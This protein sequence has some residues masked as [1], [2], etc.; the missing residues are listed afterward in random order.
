MATA[1][2]YL[3]KMDFE[4]YFS[5]AYCGRCGLKSCEDFL[6]KA[7]AGLIKPEVCVCLSKQEKYAFE[8]VR[9]MPELWPDVPLLV[10]P[11]RSFVGLMELNE[12]NEKSLILLTGNNEFTQQILMTVL[13]TTVCPFFVLCADTDG[14]TVDMSMIYET[15]T[16]EGIR[17]QISQTDLENRSVRKEM[18]IPGLAAPLKDEIEKLTGWHVRVGPL[19]AA[20]LPLFLSDVWL[21]P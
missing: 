7:R 6:R 20:E 13:G 9:K 5:H 17:T 8:V 11:R 3:K 18:I 14:N 4:K 21:P 19:C 10:H 12:P 15:L 2:L 1:D 16:C